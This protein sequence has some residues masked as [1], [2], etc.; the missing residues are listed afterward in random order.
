[1]HVCTRGQ[2]SEGEYLIQPSKADFIE[3][4][5]DSTFVRA[6]AADVTG[7]TFHTLGINGE[8]LLQF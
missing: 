2:R 8:V 1:M 3:W 6:K 7:T 5:Y 4:I